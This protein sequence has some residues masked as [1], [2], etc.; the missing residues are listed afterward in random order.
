MLTIEIDCPFW[1]FKAFRI[2]AGIFTLYL[3]DTVTLVIKKLHF[4]TISFQ[5]I[6][7]LFRNHAE[8]SYDTTPYILPPALVFSFFLLMGDS[9]SG[10]N[11][12]T[13]QECKYLH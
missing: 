4:A 13:W 10:I 6:R 2:S 9:C 11:F 5:P 7:L 1:I 8:Q 3:L 12:R